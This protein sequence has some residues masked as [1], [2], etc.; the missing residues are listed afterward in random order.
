MT[1]TVA[2]IGGGVSGT[3]IVLNCL[4]QATKPLRILWFDGNDAFCKGLAYSTTEDLYLL[5]VRAFNMSVFAD[6]PAH[7]VNWLEKKNLPYSG[8]HFVPRKLFGTYVLETY[9]ELKDKHTYVEIIQKPEEVTAITFKAAGYIITAKESHRANKLVLA[10][11]NFLPAHPR[12]VSQEFISSSNY[13]QD[14]FA[15]EAMRK[16]LAAK[17]VTIIGA[18][19]TMVDIV[20]ALKHKNYNGTIHVIS[21]HG[22]LPHAHNE[23]QLPAGEN[24]IDP[25][26][27]YSLSQIFSLVK[28]KLKEAFKNKL[29]PQSVIDTMRPHLQTLWIHFSIEEKKRFLR[30]LRH[31]WGVARHRAP[32][33]SMK[34]ITELI[35]DKRLTVFKGRIYNIKTKPGGFEIQYTASADG[36]NVLKTNIIIN[37]TGPEPDFNKVESP[38]IKQL[39]NSSL[40]V[41]HELAYG[42][43]TQKNGELRENVFTIGPPLKGVLWESTAVPEIRVQAKEIA[44]KI[45]FD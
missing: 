9:L 17:S 4:K 41:N 38:L 24:F 20:V 14:A 2:I 34:G 39:I 7:F 37:C 44:S 18:G 19:L 13:F 6:E 33:E 42:L 10:V 1:G 43:K 40:I 21:P 35:D 12:S 15:G 27:N 23:D 8:K 32:K 16:V 36:N 26:I 3:F 45:I 22:Y 30:H 25:S 31:K 5:N 28:V 29:N 11:G